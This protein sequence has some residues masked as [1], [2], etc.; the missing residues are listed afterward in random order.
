[1]IDDDGHKSWCK[2]QTGRRSLRCIVSIL[3]SKVFIILAGI[4]E[5][6]LQHCGIE[7]WFVGKKKIKICSFG[8]DRMVRDHLT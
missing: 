2:D 6:H 7:T 4:E 5:S 8:I 1:M 3:G